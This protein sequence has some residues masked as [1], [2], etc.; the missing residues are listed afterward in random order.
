M[1][2]Y[3]LGCD[4]HASVQP[5]VWVNATLSPMKNG[6]CRLSNSSAQPALAGAFAQA[7]KGDSTLVRRPPTL[8]L[9]AAQSLGS[10]Q[11]GSP[12]R[13]RRSDWVSPE[14]ADATR[15]GI[16]GKTASVL[17]N[18]L[19]SMMGSP[20]FRAC[21]R[22]YRPCPTRRF[23]ALDAGREHVPGNG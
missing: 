19:L 7:A 4:V 11:P 17:R 18:V 20:R 22:R 9:S 1:T 2:A 8:L 13:T 5:N 23:S 15:P 3:T 16:N 10:G 12:G 21:L 6:L 14:Q